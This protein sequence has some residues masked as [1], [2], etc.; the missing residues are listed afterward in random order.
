[1][2]IANNK[3]F[4]VLLDTSSRKISQI[5]HPVPSLPQGIRRKASLSGL[6]TTGGMLPFS[7][8]SNILRAYPNNRVVMRLSENLSA[9]GGVRGQGG[10]PKMPGRRQASLARRGLLHVYPVR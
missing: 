7:T 2:K 5:I 6:R 3:A 8:P 10:R 1:M 9:Y 4:L